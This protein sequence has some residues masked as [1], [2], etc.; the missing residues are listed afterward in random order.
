M[1]QVE[2]EMSPWGR[3][4]WQ[5]SVRPRSRLY[6]SFRAMYYSSWDIAAVVR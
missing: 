1:L 5:A 2:L 3:L 4:N 6:R